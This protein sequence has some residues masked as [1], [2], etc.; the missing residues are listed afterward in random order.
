[1]SCA[2]KGVLKVFVEL[3]GNVL[4]VLL[5][6][7]NIN[8]NN[9]FFGVRNRFNRN[10]NVEDYNTFTKQYNKVMKYAMKEL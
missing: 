4:Q 1:M 5:S 10:L 3:T 8:G 2:Q 9:T 6:P 7:T